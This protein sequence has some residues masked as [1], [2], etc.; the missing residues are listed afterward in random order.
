[1]ASFRPP[2]A[3]P[4]F[5]PRP[6]TLT[7][8]ERNGLSHER[9]TLPAFK[10]LKSRLAKYDNTLSVGHQSALIALVGLMTK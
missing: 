3:H 6:W 9:L 4:G 1:M 8:R 2:R 7:H 10:L 5:T